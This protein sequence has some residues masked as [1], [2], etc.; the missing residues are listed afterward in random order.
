VAIEHAERF[1][2]APQAEDRKLNQSSA[3]AQRALVNA[4][5]D[6]PRGRWFFKMILYISTSANYIW[7]IWMWLVVNVISWT[8]RQFLIGST[9]LED[10]HLLIFLYRGSCGNIEGI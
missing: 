2:L 5:T 7:D 10:Y 9:L 8:S 4:D 1:A 6:H 3:N